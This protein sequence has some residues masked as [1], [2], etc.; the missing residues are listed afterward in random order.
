MGDRLTHASMVN[1]VTPD[2]KPL[3]LLLF[4]LKLVYSLL[5]G[6]NL[7]IVFFIYSYALQRHLLKYEG[8]YPPTALPLGFIRGEPIFA[9]ECVQ[10]VCCII[11]IVPPVY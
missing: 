5:S 1:M 9:R 4:K 11:F 10:L 6:E 2:V 3:I 7:I 8:I